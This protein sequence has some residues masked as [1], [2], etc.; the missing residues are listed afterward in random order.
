[1]AEYKFFDLGQTL[2]LAEHIKGQRREAENDRLKN[3]YM[4]EQMK[5]MQASRERAAAEESR[6]ATQFSQDQQIANTKMLNTAA[7]EIMADESAAAR[8]MP[9]LKQAGILQGEVELT[10]LAPGQLQA[11]AKRYFDSTT[12]ALNAAGISPEARFVA[13]QRADA[14]NVAYGRDKE[15]AATQHDYRMDEIAESGKFSRER[16]AASSEHKEFRDVMSLRKEFESLDAVKNYRAVV[17][18]IN[19]AKNAPDT[20]YG[21]M[22]LIYAVGKI[23]DPESVVREGELVLTI[24]ASSPLS[25]MFGAGRFALESGGRI[26]PNA[27]QQLLQMLNGRVGALREQYDAESRRYGGYAQQNGWSQEQIIGNQPA[28]PGANG[29]GNAAPVTATGPNGQKIALINGQWVPQ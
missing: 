8:W 17:P 5:S 7:A 22:D 18:I 15:S 20:G 24:A 14:A 13:Q 12:A 10:K 9:Q 19:S 3:A 25:R 4:G 29:G 16:A 11:E 27:R 2:G 28:A 26:P 6:T 21:D 1:M 23:L